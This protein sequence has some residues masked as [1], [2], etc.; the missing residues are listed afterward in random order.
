MYD[1]KN[2]FNAVDQDTDDIVEISHYVETIDQSTESLNLTINNHLYITNTGDV[3]YKSKEEGVF[4]C[5]EYD[6][7]KYFVS[8]KS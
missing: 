4:F 3:V 2:Q 8:K 6:P 7:V 5:K 1:L